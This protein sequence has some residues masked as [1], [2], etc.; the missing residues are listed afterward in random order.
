MLEGR[1]KLHPG[2][3]F[4]FPKVI[5]RK[6]SYLFQGASVGELWVTDSACAL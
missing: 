5:E 2:T 3:S 4:Y 1:Y 6:I